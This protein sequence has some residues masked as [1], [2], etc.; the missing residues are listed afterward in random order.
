MKSSIILL[1][2]LI[3]VSMNSHHL[4][5]RQPTRE[6][7]EEMKKSMGYEPAKAGGDY[8][9]VNKKGSTCVEAGKDIIDEK[10]EGVK[11]RAGLD[12]QRKKMGE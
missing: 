7:L 5:S 4:F 11:V 3:V 2:T 12:F 6:E 10:V 1:F 8:D 9:F